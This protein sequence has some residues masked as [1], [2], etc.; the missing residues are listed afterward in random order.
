MNKEVEDSSCAPVVASQSKQLPSSSGGSQ[1]NPGSAI[2]D[3]AKG[4]NDSSQD[5][6][7]GKHTQDQSPQPAS[8]DSQKKVKFNEVVEERTLMD[9]MKKWK[10][11]RDAGQDSPEIK[12]PGGDSSSSRPKDKV[13]GGEKIQTV[14]DFLSTDPPPPPAA[15]S[16]APDSKKKKKNKHRNRGKTVQLQGHNIITHWPKDPRCEICNRCKL[17]RLFKSKI[18]TYHA[19]ARPWQD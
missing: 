13:A 9:N 17:Q 8:Q 6:G 19:S 16:E 18:R 3:S 12:V 14:D 10:A 15:D 7:E 1:G 5:C 4:K 11:L 2:P